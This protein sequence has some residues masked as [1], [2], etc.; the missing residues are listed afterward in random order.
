[1]SVVNLK[2]PVFSKVNNGKTNCQQNPPE[3]TARQ[4]SNV[5]LNK[6]ML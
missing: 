1:M 3:N 5:S 6:T 4:G 2:L